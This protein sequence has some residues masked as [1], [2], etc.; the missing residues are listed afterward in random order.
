M[1]ATEKIPTLSSA[2]SKDFRSS[3]AGRVDDPTIWL[4]RGA[5]AVLVEEQG[6]IK[7]DMEGAFQLSATQTKGPG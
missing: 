5:E 6:V 2:V 3:L 7:S 1:V 4:P